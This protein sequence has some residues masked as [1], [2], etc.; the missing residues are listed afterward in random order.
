VTVPA[1][2]QATV[3]E[4]VLRAHRTVDPFSFGPSVVS[5]GGGDDTGAA[6]GA[7]DFGGGELGVAT[8]DGDSGVPHSSEMK[9]SDGGGGPSS[10]DWAEAMLT[11]PRHISAVAISTPRQT[12]VNRSVRPRLM[13]HLFA[14]G[15]VIG[16][17]EQPT[18]HPICE[19]RHLSWYPTA[20]GLIIVTSP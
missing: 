17:T 15:G 18:M 11:D 2:R 8:S 3:T 16:G 12:R 6:A 20:S 10:D 7:D 9:G 5:G 4:S 19:P 13:S 14:S 1:V